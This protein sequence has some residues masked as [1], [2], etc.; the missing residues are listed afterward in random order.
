MRLIIGSL[1]IFSLV[2]LFLFALFP[3]DISV[4]RIVRINKPKAEVIKKIA[5]L[6]QWKNWN[7]FLYDAYGQRESVSWAMGKE[8]STQISRPYVTVD[9]LKVGQDTVMTGWKHGNKSFLGNYILS[10]DHG[11]TLV[12]WVLYFHVSWYP[13]EKL[14]SMFYEKQLGPSMERSLVKLRNELEIPDH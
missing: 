4:T 11:Q 3:A 13:W 10:D 12:A 14:A 8:D 5:D 1:L 6:R 2:I 7:D 9:L